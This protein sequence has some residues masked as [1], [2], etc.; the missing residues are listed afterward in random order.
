M[1]DI[2]PSASIVKLP[3]QIPKGTTDASS[4]LSSVSSSSSLI[5]LG[6]R[7]NTSNKNNGR[8]KMLIQGESTSSTSTSST[9][10]GPHKKR[11]QQHNCEN[12]KRN[13]QHVLPP[14]DSIVSDMQDE[15]FL[16]DD[17]QFGDGGSRRNDVEH[18]QGDKI[19]KMEEACRTILECIGKFTYEIV[20]LSCNSFIS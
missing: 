11:K 15:A 2:S 16:T 10:D 17:P 19:R 6:E 9:A 13:N 1:E 14:D 7:S 18:S 8:K 5:L 20:D 3:T 4:V 12:K